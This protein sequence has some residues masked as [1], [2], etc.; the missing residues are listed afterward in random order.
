MTDDDLLAKATRELREAGDPPLPE[1]RQTRRRIVEAA[2]R[3]EKPSRRWVWLVG[4]LAAFLLAATA[5]AATTGQL[6]PLIERVRDVF[7]GPPHVAPEETRSEPARARRPRPGSDARGDAPVSDV[8]SPAP[9]EP[10]SASPEPLTV[11][12]TPALRASAAE[13][14][15]GSGASVGG[16]SMASPTAA[17]AAVASASITGPAPAR[18]PTAAGAVASRAHGAG[19]PSEHDSPTTAGTA[20]AGSSSDDP[21]AGPAPADT[22]D[23]DLAAYREAHRTHFVQRDARAA[24]AAWDAY[25]AAHPRGSF[26][27]EARYNRALC[28]V[29]LGRHDAARQALAPFAAGDVGGGYRRADAS[30]LLD[31]L[32]GH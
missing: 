30:A 25:L 26:V 31:A 4:Q 20:S 24:L 22:A 19:G 10:A 23:P 16:A 2:G 28:L 8:T 1:L 29:R 17:S 15:P 12:G 14:L 32:D 18:Q 21:V 6:Q 5:L 9:S 7:V 11:E 3:A 13:G 27:V